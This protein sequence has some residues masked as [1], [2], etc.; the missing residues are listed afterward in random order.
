MIV[1]NVK[2]RIVSKL[3][4]DIQNLDGVNRIGVLDSE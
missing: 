3:R 1:E 4:S 2:S